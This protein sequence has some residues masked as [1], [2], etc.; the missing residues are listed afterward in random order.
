MPKHVVMHELSSV[1]KQC[2]KD[3]ITSLGQ[4]TK[5][6]SFATVKE[7]FCNAPDFEIELGKIRSENK[8]AV[9]SFCL[10]THNF[11]MGKFRMIHYESEG[12]LSAFLFVFW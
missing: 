3:Y 2:F 6:K 10:A 8:D 11:A 1:Q 7:M 5:E 4:V 9:V 12:F